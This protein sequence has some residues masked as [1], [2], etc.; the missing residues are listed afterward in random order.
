M[1]NFTN[2]LLINLNDLMFCLNTIVFNQR[3]IMPYC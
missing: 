1:M 2:T 3:K